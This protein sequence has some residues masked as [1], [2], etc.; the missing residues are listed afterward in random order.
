MSFMGIPV[1]ASA[2]LVFAAFLEPTVVYESTTPTVGGGDLNRQRI[3]PVV[4]VRLR[5][6]GARGTEVRVRAVRI[7]VVSLT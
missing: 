2:N 5:S 1:N 4:T 3:A 7:R 6:W